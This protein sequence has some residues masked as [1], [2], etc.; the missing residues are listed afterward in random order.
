MPGESKENCWEFKKCGREEGGA[1]TGE[2]GVC[3]AA[4]ES[5]VDGV[6]DGKNGGR[7]CWAVSKTLCVGKVEGSFSAKVTNC[8][9][10]DFYRQVCREQGSGFQGTAQILHILNS[11]E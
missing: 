4:T 5:R 7:A 1:R 8:M 10:C 3:P 11:Q 9:L 6:N 2:L